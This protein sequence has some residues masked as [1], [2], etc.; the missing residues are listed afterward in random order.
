[1]GSRGITIR[2]VAALAT[3]GVLLATT[4]TASADSDRPAVPASSIGDALSD[5]VDDPYYPQ[6][7]EPYFDALKYKLDLDWRPAKER[8]R[9]TATIR[10]RVTTDRRTVRLD[11]GSPLRVSRVVLDGRAR[12]WIHPRNHL[13]VDTGRLGADSRHTL[14]VTYAG[15]PHQVPA[16]TTR[17][18]FP[19]IGWKTLPDGSTW[20]MQEPWG[21]FTWYPVN[22]HPSDKAF[23]TARVTSHGGMNNVFNG[24]LDS[25][26]TAHGATTSHWT[27]QQPA[28]SYLVTL[29]IG[30][31]RRVADT[32]PHGLPMSYWVPRGSGDK[33]VALLRESPAIFRWIEA[34]AGRYRFARGGAVVVDSGSAMETQTMLTMGAGDLESARGPADLMHEYAHQWL[35]DTVTTD[36]WPDLWLNEGLTMYLQVMWEAEHGGTPLDEHMATYAELDNQYRAANGPPGAWHKEDFGQAVVYTSPALVLHRIR[37]KVGDTVFFDTLKAWV[38]DHRHQSVDRVEFEDFWSTHTGIDLH[39]FVEAWLT[40]PTTP[41]GP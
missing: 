37:T 36:N 38:R 28:A 21:A 24:R 5:P 13:V 19:G 4:T 17:P 7:G 34:R 35:G 3:C 26:R 14:S 39:A 23:Y 25:T 30:H 33:D 29:A 31:Y 22:D 15:S 8:L 27:L 10:F 18:D 41:P 2:R 12:R 40:S 1:M 32:G 6:H 20:T 9:G 16:P 11:L